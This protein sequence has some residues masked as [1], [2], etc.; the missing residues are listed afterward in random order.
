MRA[1]LAL[2]LLLPLTVAA[3][4]PGFDTDRG[5]HGRGGETKVPLPQYPK[6]E[7]YLPFEVSAITPFS[8]FVDAMSISV[9]QD[10]VVR[11]TLIAKSADGALNVS[12]EG[13]R[14]SDA[15]FRVYAFGST[16]NGWAEVRD[17]KWV[18][19]RS[20]PRNGQRAVL[21]NGYFCPSAG[22]VLTADESVRALKNGG[23]PRA[24][25]HGY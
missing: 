2:A 18:P 1:W 12:F 4:A 5:E 11:Y 6:P 10:G 23:N 7:N 21:F 15:Q 20:E 13:M 25:T 3:Q 19:I 24:K 16:G 14:C 17:P 8:F 9:R 22:N